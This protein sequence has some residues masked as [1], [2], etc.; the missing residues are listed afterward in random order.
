MYIIDNRTYRLKRTAF[1]EIYDFY[2]FY[3]GSIQ[4]IKNNLEAGRK[5]N[6]ANLGNLEVFCKPNR[7]FPLGS[8]VY[9]SVVC[10][11]FIFLCFW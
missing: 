9:F 10:S 2:I 5:K 6:R 8:L 11:S 1:C 3:R 4:P 7:S